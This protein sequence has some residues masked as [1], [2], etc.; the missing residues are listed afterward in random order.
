MTLNFLS[1]NDFNNN[2]LNNDVK[3]QH[4]KIKYLNPDIQRNKSNLIMTD[5]YNLDLSSQLRFNIDY[6]KVIP[7]NNNDNKNNNDNDNDNEKSKRE[8][9]LQDN[10]LLKNTITYD[11]NKYM[12]E[13]IK[14]V[15]LD[16]SQYDFPKNMVG[17]GFGK[18]S[19]A[20]TY[21]LHTRQYDND[22]NPRQILNEDRM[23]RTNKNILYSNLI[24]D[25]LDRGG[26]DT[27]YLNK[28]KK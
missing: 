6:S 13:N 21:G 4:T 14:R 22:T 28:M 20:D 17:R 9:V 3:Q 11:N 23:F 2:L 5:N 18:M 12:T 19:S 25:N 7:F 16:I 27:R 26:I 10:K 24:G 1:L 15:P 8:K